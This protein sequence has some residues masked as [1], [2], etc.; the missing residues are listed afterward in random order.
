M[1]DTTEEYENWISDFCSLYGHDYLVEVASEFIED[2]FNL[3]GLPSM[4]P[5][6]REAL[7]LILDFEPDEPVKISD[8]PLIQHSAELLYGL[9]HQRFIITKQGL[10]MMKDKYEKKQFGICSRYLC[11]GMPLL[12]VGRQDLLGFEAVRLFCPSCLDLYLPNSSR[13][14]N[15]DGAFFGTTFAGLFIKMY[16]ELE[17]R[18]KL[19]V[20]GTNTNSQY[21]IKIFGFK[22]NEL[23][24]VGSRMKWLRQI[25]ETEEELKEYDECEYRLVQDEEMT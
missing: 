10:S 12:P 5:F 20:N 23:S 6:Y 2:D 21:I 13:Y 4:V 16:P 17:K 9:I 1:S 11:D 18:C 19:K 22:L 8:M 3:T 7:D 25:P 14:L 15:I 24:N